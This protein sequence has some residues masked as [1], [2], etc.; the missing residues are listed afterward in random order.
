[1]SSQFQKLSF[2]VILLLTAACSPVEPAS[3][4]P[5]PVYFTEVA[6]ESG[7]DFVHGAF[8]WEMSGDPVAMMGGGLCWLDFDND[9]WLDLFVVNS[10]AVAEA[11][12][13]DSEMGGLPTS[14]LYKNNSGQFADVS[15]SAG[16]AFPLRGNGCVAADWNMDGWTD[17]Y[18]TTERVNMLLWNNGDGT[19][20]DD[21]AVAGVD[22]YGWQ[23]TAVSGDL[24]GDGW[25][26]LFVA[27][28]VDMNNRIPD[29]TMGFPNSHLPRRDFL[30][31]S[32]GVNETGEVTFRE[33]GELVG[34]KMD[35]YEYGLGALL[36]DVD[37]DGDL[38]LYVANDTNPNRLYEN[39]SM[40]DDPEEIGFRLQE[41][42][43]VAQVNDG[44][45]GMGVAGGDYDGNGRFDL[46]VTNMGAQLHA[47][48]QNQSANE[49]LFADGVATS[50]IPNLGEGWTGWGTS[51]GDFDNDRDLDLIV[52]NGAIPVLD[53]V[54]D[55]QAL[56]LLLNRTAQGETAVLTDFSLEAGLSSIE[57]LLGRGAAVADYDNDGDLD[58]AVSVIGEPLV[59]LRNETG[60]SNWLMVDVGTN[61]AGATVTAVLPDGTQLHCEIYAGSSYLSSEDPR[62]HFGLGA[63]IQVSQLNVRWPGGQTVMLENV[64]ANQI[65]T[66]GE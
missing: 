33:V 51:W 24:N 46:F 48:F 54:A 37:G 29:A 62:C 11:G 30:F 27:G 47:L 1:M 45:S 4:A 32:N 21:G 39:V 56:Q 31:I 15:D 63:V 8:R 13:W 58:V 20:R 22:M 35:A 16:V 9:G 10:Y 41:I 28:Y 34:L 38:D 14:R 5:K 7:L 59:L 26:D 40:T 53:K 65:L 57:P 18:I 2:I 36:T 50:T 12:R 55:R 61:G 49:P 43:G 66:V 6:Q 52:A 44:N 23:T 64:L 42:G 17:L 3:Y 19:F 60:G 25:P